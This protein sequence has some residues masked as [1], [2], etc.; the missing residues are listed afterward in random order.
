MHYA[1][2]KDFILVA[3]L[4]INLFKDIFKKLCLN[5][6][7]NYP[8]KPY[9]YLFYTCKGEVFE[10]SFRNNADELRVR[11]RASL[12]SIESKPS[13]STVR[14]N[15]PEVFRGKGVLKICNKFKGSTHAEV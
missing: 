2:T 10:K 3:I 13:S 12:E 14:S 7:I 5:F 4:K 6:Q 15:H 8:R 1:K 9:D 11:L